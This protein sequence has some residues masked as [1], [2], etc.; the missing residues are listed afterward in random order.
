MS[1]GFDKIINDL[2]QI[3]QEAGKN[4]TA[5]MDAQAEVRRIEGNI[6]WVH[7]AGGVDETPVR[8]TINA[9]VGD[10]VQV[11][12]G[13]GRAWITGNFDSPPTDDTTANSAVVM[14][15]ESMIAAEGASEAA[16]RAEQTAKEVEQIAEDAQTS[17]DKAKAAADTATEAANTATEAIVSVVDGAQTVEK[18]V[19]VMQTA[20]EAVVDYDPDNDIVQEYFWHDA[21][22]AHVLGDTSGYRNDIDS[23]GMKIMDV[24]SE[25]SV[26]EF[27]ANNTVIGKDD[28]TNARI[29]PNAFILVDKDG[30]PYFEVKDW[31][32]K[33]G[34][35]TYQFT[36]N[37]TNRHFYCGLTATSASDVT[38]T[39]DGET[40]IASVTRV[41]PVIVSFQ[42]APASGAEI[43]IKYTPVAGDYKDLTFGTRTDK[44]SR[45]FG[46]TL[47]KE[48]IVG[49]NGQTVIGNYNKISNNVAFVIGI[50]TADNART[51]A[52]EVGWNGLIYCKNASGDLWDILYIINPAYG[53]I[54]TSSSLFNPADMWG[55]T[56][57][58]EPIKDVH[59]VDE[60]IE[61]NWRYVKYS[62]GRFEMSRV[63]SGAPTG[64]SHYATVGNL[65]GY[66]VENIQFPSACMPINTNYHVSATWIVDSGFAM[67]AGTVNSKTTSKFTVY[68]LASSASQT[69]VNVNLHVTG[70]WDEEITTHGVL[71]PDTIYRWHRI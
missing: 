50:G 27:G 25:E 16:M 52:L 69:T 40:A 11:R 12:L 14:S 35:A 65:Y 64:G 21:N 61:N 28:G 67:S 17:A 71:M 43:E 45:Y 38:V 53:Y 42:T 62:D 15:S 23:S 10:K 41:N 68:C 39:V 18:A 19:S 26:A 58:Q 37:G 59:V 55:G 34:Y 31:V 44:A 54:E 57:V 47:G 3:F 2:L 48:L 60:G 63:Y 13:G 32:D 51:N 24:S 20:L 33:D 5:P 29:T 49:S 36:G 66:R 7:I 4:K 1:S 8:L 70:L 9:R 56:W 30:N 6:A 46:S 22:G